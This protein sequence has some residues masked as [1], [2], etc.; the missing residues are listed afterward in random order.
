MAH[1]P[2]LDQPP[3]R[4]GPRIEM[5]QT[6]IVAGFLGLI[7]WFLAG[8][9]L[10]SVPVPPGTMLSAG[11]LVPGPVRSIDALEAKVVV[12]GFTMQCQECHRLFPSQPETPRRLTQHQEIRLD[13]GLNDRCFNCHDRDNRDRL[14]LRGGQTVSFA[15]VPLLCAKCHGPTFRDWEEGM[16]G[17]SLG[18]WNAELGPRRRLVCSEC[19]DPHGPA[20]EI[21]RPYPGPNTLRMGPQ[22]HEH[23]S[24]E[25]MRNPLRKWKHEAR[26]RHP[27]IPQEELPPPFSPVAEH[28]E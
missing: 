28:P 27:M 5:A 24:A 3:A 16:H 19:H 18:T 6:L 25:D 17:L 13:H 4:H 26:D 21:M 2:D 1:R 20:Y 23:E 9:R 14:A 22:H 15:E 8:P 7:L 11:E 10:V 12:A